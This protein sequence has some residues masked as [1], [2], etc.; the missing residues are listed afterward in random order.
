MRL[1][2]RSCA[3]QGVSLVACPNPNLHPNKQK[4]IRKCAE[5]V[6]A[7]QPVEVSKAL[8]ERVEIL[9]TNI[10]VMV[11][12]VART[13]NQDRYW[14]EQL[15]CMRKKLRYDHVLLKSDYWKKFAGG[16]VH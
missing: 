1:L 15:K 11:G 5:R 2:C 8:T 14:P 12:H 13:A 9:C 3:I 4:D 7:T 16:S 6:V 10:D